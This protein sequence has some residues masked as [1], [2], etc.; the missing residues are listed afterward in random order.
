MLVAGQRGSFFHVAASGWVNS[1]YRFEYWGDKMNLR[2]WWRLGVYFLVLYFILE[3]SITVYWKN[4]MV[5]LYP[6]DGDSI[7]MPI[8]ST[9]FA[10]FVSAFPLF[11]LSFL[12]QAKFLSRFLSRSLWLKIPVGVFIFVLYGFGVLFALDGSASV[13]DRDHYPI[14][15]SHIVLLA[16]MC[17]FAYF[18]VRWFLSLKNFHNCAQ[19]DRR[20]ENEA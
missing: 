14:G 5:G 15:A 4:Q 2:S 17:W 7:G 10:L 3:V 1:V 19:A 12:P 9:M 18:D 13:L 8:Y 16:V 20:Q 11:V 6:S